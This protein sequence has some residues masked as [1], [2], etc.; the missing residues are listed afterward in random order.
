MNRHPY[1]GEEISD[2]DEW[3]DRG[4]VSVPSVP[5]LG[6][7]VSF[8]EWNR[9]KQSVKA[10][11]STESQWLSGTYACL[12]AGIAFTIAAVS[13]L[14]LDSASNWMFIAFCALGAAGLLSALVC[15]IAFRGSRRQKQRDIDSVI[16]FMNDIEANYTN[17]Q[18]E[19]PRT[20]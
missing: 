1:D 4:I 7:T 15:L 17:G 2:W 16:G 5:Q 8:R 6:F 19:Q 11:R 10:I 9:I 20:Q 12:S 18:D 3:Y 14:Q 13:L